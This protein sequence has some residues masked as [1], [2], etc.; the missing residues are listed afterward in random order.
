M[1][2]D[3]LKNIN[4][5]CVLYL[6]VSS[7][8]QVENYSLSNQESTC[9]KVAE[10]RGLNILEIFREEGASAKTANRPELIKLLEYCR[11][12]KDNIALVMFYRIDRLARQISD[13]LTIKRKLFELGITLMSATEP[14]EDTPTGKFVET[15]L[16]ASAQLDNDVRGARSS[17]GLYQRFRD[18]LPIGKAPLGYQNT[19]V[20][21]KQVVIPNETEFQLVKKAWDLVTTG[22]KSTR[23]MAEIM[24]SWGLRAVWGKKRYKLR[25][26]TVCRIFR[27]IIYT[28]VLKYDKYPNEEVV[29]KYTPMITKEQFY[30]VQDILDGRR[31]TPMGSKRKVD[32][33]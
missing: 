27:S 15:L 23:E 20:G 7:E 4:M 30:R 33:P 10:S 22:T 28:G 9:R 21:E 6:R 31:T 24:N 29:G 26:Q 13:Y 2:K 3:I 19:T 14:T 18:G 11:K 8:E 32:N 1:N 5:N 16:A 12:H 17:Q 25:S